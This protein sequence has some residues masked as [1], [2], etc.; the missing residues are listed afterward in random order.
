MTSPIYEGAPGAPE[1]HALPSNSMWGQVNMDRERPGLWIETFDVMSQLPYNEAALPTTDGPFHGLRA[2]SSTG[3]T[4]AQVDSDEAPRQLVEATDNESVGIAKGQYPFKIIQG[5]G[6]L[7]FE[8]RV[9]KSEIVLASNI[10]VGLL[11]DIALTVDIPMST[12]NPPILSDH[13]MVGFFGAEG[14]PTVL[15]T[16]YKANGVTAVVVKTGAVTMVADTYVKLGMWFNRRNDNVLEFLKD[17]VFLADTKF[18][19]DEDPADGTDF[20]NDVRLGWCV[21]GRGGAASS[22]NHT[23]D[24]VRVAQ[25]KITAQP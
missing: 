18:I 16:T 8:A 12:A 1:T 14:T 7:I 21:A 10:F 23:L 24:W 19:P 5:H 25:K 2:F 6:E 3:G 22:V 15:A 4:F 13:N 11:Q 17:G 9:K 20:P